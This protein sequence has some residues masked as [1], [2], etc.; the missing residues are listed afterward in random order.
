MSNLDFHLYK[1]FSEYATQGTQYK[2]SVLSIQG[3]LN[4]CND[5][6]FLNETFTQSTVRNIANTAYK[7]C[8]H[9]TF[10]MF[11]ELTAKFTELRFTEEYAEDPSEAFSI[12]I[13]E[14]LIPLAESL[15]HRNAV[16]RPEHLNLRMNITVICQSIHPALKEIYKR[17]FPWELK[18]GP[19]ELYFEKS[20]RGLE[21]FLSEIDIYPQSMNKQKLHGL[22][23][24]VVI[25]QHVKFRECVT[26][27]LIPAKM[28]DLGV[29]FTLSKFVLFFYFCSIYGFKEVAGEDKHTENFLSMLERVQTIISKTL[30]SVKLVPDEDVLTSIREQE[31]HSTTGS[32]CISKELW[33]A[34]MP[35]DLSCLELYEKHLSKLRSTF[36]HYSAASTSKGIERASFQRFLRDAGLLE[37]CELSPVESDLIF[38]RTIAK[39]KSQIR[40]KL[41]FLDFLDSLESV[42]KKVYTSG[43]LSS[44]MSR[45]LEHRLPEIPCEAPSFQANLL[46]IRDSSLSK[47]LKTVTK[48]VRAYYSHY[49]DSE[50]SMSFES[51]MRLCKDFEIFPDILSRVKLHSIFI[52]FAC[53][54]DEELSF[55][56]CSV[57]AVCESVDNE[58]DS[59]DCASFTEALALV[60]CEICCDRTYDIP[61]KL[62]YLIERMSQSAGPAVFYSETGGAAPSLTAPLK[63]KFPHLLPQLP[64]KFPDFKEMFSP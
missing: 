21:S 17:K 16:L 58:V 62:G 14:F 12:L 36:L 49:A 41:N 35:L 28:T 15:S 52:K 44:N 8:L 24:D 42:A 13:L 37:E 29:V 6:G 57:H 5:A 32:N 3:L 30:R 19:I 55:D 38:S 64:L 60:S 43:S 59:I 4:L 7:K 18:P 39:R 48:S 33:V 22:W 2:Q 20:L 11:C 54:N 23:R 26:K 53:E 25:M 61:Q 50:G 47:I 1:V 34:E 63:A 45:L 56:V 9:L 31:I 10:S 51:F 40:R 46:K 27:A